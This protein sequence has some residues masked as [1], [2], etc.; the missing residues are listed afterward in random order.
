MLEHQAKKMSPLSFVPI[1][2]L[3]GA[4]ARAD[5]S[6]SA[7]GGRRELRYVVNI[8]AVTPSPSDF[9]AERDW[10]RSYW[11]ALVEHAVGVGGYVNFM[12]E[13]EEDRVRNA[14]GAKY[15]RLQKVK[16]QYDP[17]NVFHLNP[18][19]PPT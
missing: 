16:A 19:I 13:Y 6:D 7:F 9:N 15:E 2:V 8:S 10:V 11:S 5:D 12:T 3:G 18:N 14:D 4:Y 1:F 17:D